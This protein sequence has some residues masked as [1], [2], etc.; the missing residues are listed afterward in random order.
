MVKLVA[1]MKIRKDIGTE[2]AKRMYEEEHVPLVLKS[3]PMVQDY[4]RSY[5]SDTDP[6]TARS[7]RPISTLLPNFGSITLQTS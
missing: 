5:L 1:L 6:L 2:E 3:M 4:R 7:P